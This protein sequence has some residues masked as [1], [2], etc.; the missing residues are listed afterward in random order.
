MTPAIDLGGH[1]G[2][3]TPQGTRRAPF[4]ATTA[5]AHVRGFSIVEDR[6]WRNSE[7]DGRAG[8]EVRGQRM[9][10]G[11]QEAGE[12]EGHD[13]RVEEREGEREDGGSANARVR[14]VHVWL[15]GVGLVVGVRVGRVEAV[16]PGG[17]AGEIRR[18]G[19]DV[20]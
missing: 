6:L 5:V 3:R 17:G 13:H 7:P 14:D 4:H 19:E 2:I 11:T 15:C 12:P 18:Q 10:G 8:T 16:Y 1:R 9:P 20:G